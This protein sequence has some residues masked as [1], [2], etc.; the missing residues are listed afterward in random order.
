MEKEKN[1]DRK[2]NTIK[3]LIAAVL[4]A[5]VFVV[6]WLFVAL[7]VWGIFPNTYEGPGYARFITAPG[8]DPNQ[9]SLAVSRTTVLNFDGVRLMESEF[10]EGHY[11]CNRIVQVTDTYTLQNQGDTSV[12]FEL[13][14]PISGDSTEQDDVTVTVD[15]I[16]VADW[17]GMHSFV[18]VDVEDYEQT[19]DKRLCD[20]TDFAMAFPH[21]PERGTP[22][23]VLDNLDN[24]DEAKGSKITYGFAYYLQTVT[25]PAGGSTVVRATYPLE[26]TGKILFPACYQAI[27]CESHTLVIEHADHVKLEDENLSITDLSGTVE[28]NLDPARTDYFM[29]FDVEP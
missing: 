28:L 17:W 14:Y 24:M 12:S 4:V 6:V 23:S 19:I 22:G 7:D 18:A 5:I 16:P 26:H 13:I 27:A 11:Y 10:E 2:S 29:E 25:I 9:T 21:W 8:I 15:E 1:P 3:I 20:G